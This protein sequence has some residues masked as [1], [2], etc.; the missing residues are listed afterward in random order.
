VQVTHEPE[1]GRNI[2]SGVEDDEDAMTG[3]GGDRVRRVTARSWLEGEVKRG[4]DLDMDGELED[5]DEQLYHLIQ[6]IPA[7]WTVAH[8]LRLAVISFPD[9]AP[10]YLRSVIST[11]FLTLR[12][13]AQHILM[14]SIRR[15]PAVNPLTTMTVP[16]D[17]DVVTSVHLIETNERLWSALEMTVSAS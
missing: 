7:P 6:T 9:R 11:I 13:T 1:T 15:A 8:V 16:L 5:L 2:I 14:Q 12:K 10:W 3:A 4:D 17:M